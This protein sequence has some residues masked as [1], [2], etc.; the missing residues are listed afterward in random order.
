MALSYLI[1]QGAISAHGRTLAEARA[2]L[3]LKQGDRDTTPYRGW[4]TRTVV[5]K[6][7][8]I[9]AYRAVTGACGLGVSDWLAGRRLPVRLSVAR[10][11]RETAGAYGAD[12][13]AAFIHASANKAVVR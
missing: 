6:D 13:F 3:R 5:S 7:E 11:L 4:T 1:T 9:A 12:T 10:I 2:D 8:A